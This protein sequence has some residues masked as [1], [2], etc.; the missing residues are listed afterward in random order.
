MREK[1]KLTRVYS[2]TE[3]L[4]NLLKGRLEYNGISTLI[5]N[6]S[7]TAYLESNPP[8]SIDLYI[9]EGDLKKAESIINDFIQNNKG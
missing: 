3:V 8:P 7:I 4:V 1:N 5:K 9:Q 6:D 2:G